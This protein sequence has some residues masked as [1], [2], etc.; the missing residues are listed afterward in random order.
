MSRLAGD[1]VLTENF[2]RKF[3]EKTTPQLAFSGKTV[4]DAA[5]WQGK[6]KAKVTELLGEFPEPADL[7]PDLLG[8]EDCG[9]FVREKYLIQTEKDCF[10]PLYLLLPKNRPPKCPAILCCHGHGPHG[11]DSVAGVHFNI[12]ERKERIE[13]HNYNYA[14]QMAERGYITIAPD[15]RSFGERV[16]YENKPYGARD[17][18]NVHFIQ[19]LILG[20]TLLGANIF[21]GM[22]AIDFLLT[23]DDVDGD[24]LGCMG[25]SFGGTMTTYITLFDQRIKAA[26]IICYAT[27]THHYAIDSANFCGS[28]FVPNIYKYADVGH[29]I[30]TIAPRPLLLESGVDD[31]CFHLYSAREAHDIVKGIYEAA[32]AP[33]NLEIDIFPGEHAF[34]GKVAFEFFDKHLMGR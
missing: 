25:L 30:G 1:K 34:A 3:Y 14:E 28:Q 16:G 29:I 24:R 18:C 17:K 23:R 32:D 4:H 20:R 27:T 12:E 9:S 19:H 21:D 15:F 7:M 8:T 31:T 2:I 6:L 10:M 22:R 26:D 5:E 33:D 11:K 13:F